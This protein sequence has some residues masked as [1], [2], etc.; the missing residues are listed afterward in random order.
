MSWV[1]AVVGLLAGS[2]RAAQSLRAS[3]LFPLAFIS[4]AFVPSETLPGILQ[5][6][7]NWN[8]VTS[9]AGSLREC[10]GNPTSVNPL[11][12]EPVTWPPRIRRC[13]SLS[14]LVI[15]LVCIPLAGQL[16]IVRSLDNNASIGEFC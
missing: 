15:V 12:P 1:G 2:P 3:I 4:S 13:T 8:P 9:V 16:W 11:L 7:A 5:D 14:C 10:F 6:V